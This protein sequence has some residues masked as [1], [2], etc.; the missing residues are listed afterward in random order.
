MLRKNKSQHPV[1]IMPDSVRFQ[2][3]VSLVDFMYHGE[4]AVPSEELGQFMNTAKQFKVRGLVEDE[5]APARHRVQ[6]RPPGPHKQ[7]RGREP[8]DAPVPPD[9]R[10]RLPPGIHMVRRGGGEGTPEKRPRLHPPAGRGGP[11]QHK[12]GHPNICGCTR[13]EDSFPSPT[14]VVDV[15]FPRA[16]STV[17]R[18]RRLRRLVKKVMIIT[19][20]IK[21]TMSRG[22]T[23]RISSPPRPAR[24]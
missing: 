15:S 24:P 11:G 7:H 14:I 9:I 13:A 19:R 12:A 20:S 17:R 16:V 2:D 10:H 22:V 5:V 3:L 6:P 23:R 1:L 8:R 4:V 21:S 18:R